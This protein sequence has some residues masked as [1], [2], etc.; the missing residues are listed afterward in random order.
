M[1][2]SYFHIDTVY[3]ILLYHTI[4]PYRHVNKV[5]SI[6]YWK[7][8]PELYKYITANQLD[9]TIEQ[10]NLQYFYHNAALLNYIIRYRIQFKNMHCDNYPNH[11]TFCYLNFNASEIRQI[12]FHCTNTLRI[13]ILKEM[14]FSLHLRH[15][16]DADDIPTISDI[17]FFSFDGHNVSLENFKDLCYSLHLTESYLTNPDNRFYTN[18]YGAEQLHIATYLYYAISPTKENFNLDAYITS[19]YKYKNVFNYKL[20]QFLYETVGFTKEE[21]LNVYLK[22]NNFHSM[23]HNDAYIHAIQY[24]HDVV[25]LTIDHL[26]RNNYKCFSSASHS[27]NAHLAQYVNEGMGLTPDD[28]LNYHCVLYFTSVKSNEDINVLSYHENTNACPGRILN[29]MQRNIL[30]NYSLKSLMYMHTYIGMNANDFNKACIED[31]CTDVGWSDDYNEC[32]ND[33]CIYLLEA[34]GCDVNNFLESRYNYLMAFFYNNVSLVDFLYT[35]IGVKSDAFR[36]LLVDGICK[37]RS[38][39]M[40]HYLYTVVGVKN[41]DFLSVGDALYTRYSV[42]TRNG[43]I[44]NDVKCFLNEALATLL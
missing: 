32:N 31:L 20:L 30:K 9:L 39:N 27:N 35:C 3:H 15:Y 29:L 10:N 33:S 21:L 7:T 12:I 13:D 37:C 18:C 2:N 40:I 14:S 34:V 38:V 25:G 28:F 8:C 11:N 26:R 4:L 6:V 24:L 5:W 42:W 23:M 17:F 1:S 36:V 16:L 22:E 19:F 41:E 43:Y 44:M